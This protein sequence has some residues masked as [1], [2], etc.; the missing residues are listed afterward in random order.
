V[1][2][3]LRPKLS[4]ANVIST[5]ALFVALG[6]SSYAALRI[7][8]RQIADNSIR[9]VDVRNHSLTRRDIK[10]NTLDGSTIAE[11]R[12]G[13][14]PQ[15]H[16]ADRLGGLSVAELKIRCPTATLAVA[17]VCVEGTPRAPASYGTAVLACADTNVPATPGRRLPTHAELRAA[18]GS[19]PLAGGGELTSQVFPSGTDPG[20]VD[21]LYVTDQVG[22]VAITPGTG[23]GAKAFR[24]VADPLN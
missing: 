24:C 2:S 5:L 14:V 6:G 8:S 12:L 7:G 19:L 23:A 18:L 13:K 3:R 4:Y 20:E 17:D 11:S 22:H 21:V 15:A 10:R 9:S 1:F 16:D